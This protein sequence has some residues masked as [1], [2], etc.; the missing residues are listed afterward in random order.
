MSEYLNYGAL[1][2]I[3]FIGL[4]VIIMHIS[5]KEMPIFFYILLSIM[6]GLLFTDAYTKNSTAIKNI[7]DF[8]NNKV[9]LKCISG[10][11]YNSADRYRVSIKDGWSV[12]KHYFIKDSLVI[13]ASSCERW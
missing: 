3:V 12:D 11:I 9:V 6:L 7:K 5:S 1:G 4:I 8:K 10:G 2:L 13:G